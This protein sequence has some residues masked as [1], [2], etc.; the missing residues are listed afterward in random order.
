M[1]Y[2]KSANSIVYSQKIGIKINEK[3][4]TWNKN[5]ILKK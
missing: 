4:K 3:D 5:F 2:Y 1:I